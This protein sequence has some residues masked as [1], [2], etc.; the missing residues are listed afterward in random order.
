MALSRQGLAKKKLGALIITSCWGKTIWFPPVMTSGKSVFLFTLELGMRQMPWTPKTPLLRPGVS[1][2]NPGHLL[3]WP[4]WWERV[5]RATTIQV[6]VAG[7]LEHCGPRSPIQPL[8]W[9]NPTENLSGAAALK[10]WRW[11]FGLACLMGSWF[12]QCG[13]NQGHPKCS[14][15]AY[16]LELKLLKKGPVQGEHTHPPL[17]PE[18]S[19]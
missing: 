1:P 9:R 19:K 7:V 17:S 18:N 13:V 3:L 12:Y 5:Q 14:T 11:P 6:W 10:W 8:G 16:Y 4:A 2:H 15:I